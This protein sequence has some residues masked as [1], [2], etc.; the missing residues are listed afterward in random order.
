MPAIAFLLLILGVIGVIVPI[1]PGIPLLILA[2]LLFTANSPGLRRRLLR[3]PR[4]APHVQR[5]D[6]FVSTPGADGLTAWQRTKL[7]A[8]S[9]ISA[10]PL[11]RHRR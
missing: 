4:L 5:V 11:K 9:A 2:A 10:L 6:A 8:L 1:L 7:R 3:S